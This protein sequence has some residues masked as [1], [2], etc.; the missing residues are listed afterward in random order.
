[1][2][3]RSSSSGF[4]LVA[5]AIL[6]VVAGLIVN[7]VAS[8]LNRRIRADF[9]HEAKISLRHARSEI[10]GF[11][12]E[13]CELPSANPADPDYFLNHVGRRLGRFREGTHYVP[14]PAL[15]GLTGNALASFSGNT[16]LALDIPGVGTVTGLAYLVWTEGANHR[17]ELGA[18]LYMNGGVAT[19]VQNPYQE[20]QDDDLVDYVS[21]TE[22]K[23]RIVNC[24]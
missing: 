15:A 16:R 14:A 20:S 5:V 19:Y 1:M 17:D 23:N 18:T 3:H 7:S 21:F 22:L 4:S 13:R 24:Q 11:I 12:I 2:N 10:V 9:T 6:L 8:L